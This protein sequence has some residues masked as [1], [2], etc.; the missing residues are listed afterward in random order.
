[1]GLRLVEDLVCERVTSSVWIHLDFD[2]EGRI[3]IDE[4]RE[5]TGREGCP[6]CA[7]MGSGEDGL[8]R[9]AHA[10]LLER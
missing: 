1:M 8:A 4:R 9:V 6:L 7:L 2:R 10:V 5:I 3:R